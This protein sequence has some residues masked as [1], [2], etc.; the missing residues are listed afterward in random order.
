M[1]FNLMEIVCLSP[2]IWLF[3]ISLV[4]IS[5]KAFSGGR[6]MPA[7]QSLIWGVLGL[8]GAAGLTLSIV[9]GYWEV[10]GFKYVEIFSSF[11]IVDGISIWSMYIIFILAGFSLFLVY[12]S[13]A[14]RDS[15]F[16]EHL[17]LIMNSTVGMALVVMSNNLIMTFIAIELMSLSLYLL[18]ALSKEETLSKEASF[19]YFVLGSL[20]SAIF[21][22]GLAY[23]YGGSGSLN[24]HTIGDQAAGLY[25]SSSLFRFGVIMTVIGFAFK[26]SLVPFHSWTP[27]VYQGSATPVTSVMSTVVK[28]ASFVGFLRFF[29]YADYYDIPSD[30]F[31][32][33]MQWLAALTMIIGNAAALRQE[34]FKRMLAYSSI[35]H[36]GYAFMGIIAGAFGQ[37]GDG[38]STSLLFYLFSYSIMTLGTLALVNVFEKNENTILHVSDLKGLGKKSPVLA[39]ALALLLFSLAGLPPTIGF[40]GKFYIFSAALEQGMIWLTFVGVLSSMIGLYY[41]LRPIVVMYMGDGEP[42]AQNPKAFFSRSLVYLSAIAVTVLGIF[43]SKIFDFVQNSVGVSL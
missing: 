30:Q 39:L 9:N 4:P 5:V 34:N 29:V 42:V 20:G 36:S 19:K 8:L 33:F 16:S 21:L 1:D 31:F 26:I 24:L 41:Y 18:I 13:P 22:Y 3:L 12:D 7:F 32:V 14:T 2:V 17:F 38:G 28:I 43:S 25:Q 23:I 35:A 37:D 11:L 40:F 6:E 10:S 27:D 15:Q